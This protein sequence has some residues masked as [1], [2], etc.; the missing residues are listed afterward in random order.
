MNKVIV[1]IDG[2]N[3]YFGLKAIKRKDLY[4]LNLVKLGQNLLKHDQILIGVKYFTS[5]I[6]YP[7]DK[8][9]RQGAFIEATENLEN[10][11]IFYGNYMS[12]K[13]TCRNCGFYYYEFSEKKTDV[14]LAIELLVD[15]YLDKYDTAIVV[16]GDSDLSGAI[17][18]VLMLFPDK[19]VIT[20]FPPLRVSKELKT[21]STA[22]INIRKQTLQKSLLPSVIIKNNGYMLECPE[23]WR[24]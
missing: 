15:A 12:T 20:A 10:M 5:R 8:V 24:K 21:V 11:E 16:S 22:T 23:Y 19:R 13:K 14:N 2:F 18:K 7:P 3:L 6:S 1:F 4:W 9:K 17:S